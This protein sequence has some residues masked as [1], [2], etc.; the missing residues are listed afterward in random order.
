MADKLSSRDTQGQLYI[1]EH[2][3]QSKGGPPRH[4]HFEQDEWFYVV[5]GEYALKSA[6]RS[7]T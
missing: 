2:R 6:G 7:F 3:N 5:K 4:V 1:F